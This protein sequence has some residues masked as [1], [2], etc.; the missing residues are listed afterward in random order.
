MVQ[1]SHTHMPTENTIALTIWTFV[2][3]VMSLFLL[4]CLG[5]SWASFVAQLVKNQSACN[6]GDVGSIP[7]LG[8]SAG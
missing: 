1:L 3:K 2:G 4:C 8:R 5:S 7:G 6:E